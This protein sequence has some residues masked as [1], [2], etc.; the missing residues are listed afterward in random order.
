MVNRRTPEVVRA[1][2][3][4]G[5]AGSL[6]HRAAAVLQEAPAGTKAL[7]ARVLGLARM[8]EGGAAARAVFALL[9]GDSR[10]AVDAAGVWSLAPPP[11]PPADLRRERWVVV[12]VET[13]GGSP[14][15]G[16]RVTEIA[17][18]QVADGRVRDVFT[19][20]INPGRPIP[21]MITRLTGITNQMVAGA[22][23]FRDVAPRLAPLLADR[24]FV[25][26]NAPFDWRF[27]SAE[28]A[29]CGQ[30]LPPQRQLCTVRLARK[31]LPQLPSRS[32]DALADYFALDIAARH[33][34]ADD[35]IA[36][37]HVLLR[38]LDMLADSEVDHWSALQLLLKKRA[39]RRKKT[40]LPHSMDSA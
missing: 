2:E 6:L 12:D 37:A 23:R 35:A 25:A 34:A 22:P 33:R 40:R 32:L 36:T 29:L 26:H 15:H 1:A 21:G 31:L 4:F 11:E 24:V 27:V 28:M 8:G 14:H 7:A 5:P 3:A 39:P 9:G 38:F 13:T 16:H 10:F 18:V 17:A 30:A 20:L 19:T